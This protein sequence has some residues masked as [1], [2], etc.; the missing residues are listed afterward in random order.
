MNVVFRRNDL[1]YA[2]NSR[3]QSTTTRFRPE[4]VTNK[5]QVGC[6]QIVPRL[7]QFLLCS[8]NGIYGLILPRFIT[9]VLLPEIPNMC[10][11]WSQDH[12]RS[13][14]SSVVHFDKRI[15]LH[16]LG[17]VSGA[18]ESE[19]K[20]IWYFEQFVNSASGQEWLLVTTVVVVIGD[21]QPVGFTPCALAP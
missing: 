11:N 8:F 7:S 9:K 4:C 6:W 5:K 12:L 15:Y 18:L 20:V 2:E 16:R 17:R 19:V 3:K 1:I 21:S 13:P 10:W 14:Y